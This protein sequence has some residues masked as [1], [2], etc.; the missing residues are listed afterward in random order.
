MV[1]IED[2]WH[3]EWIGTF[4]SRDE[5]LAQLTR[6]AEL[7]WD[8][9]PNA[10]PCKSWQTCGR[11]YHLIHYETKS[12]PWHVLMDEPFLEVSAKGVVWLKDAPSA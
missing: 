1:V 5:A 4:Q 6:L 12:E 8:E 10:C 2:E 9:A 11:S 7:P 3:A